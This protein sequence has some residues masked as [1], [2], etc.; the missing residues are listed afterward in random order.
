MTLEESGA[1]R[2]HIWLTAHVEPTLVCVRIF[3]YVSSLLY[4]H[5]LPTPPGPGDHSKDNLVFLFERAIL[6]IL[7]T[8]AELS[9]PGVKGSW[10]IDCVWEVWLWFK[11]G[12]FHS[13]RSF[14][15][16]PFFLPEDNTASP[17]SSHHDLG[18]LRMEER[19]AR[20]VCALDSLDDGWGTAYSFTPGTPWELI[21]F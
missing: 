4:S 1:E 16:F 10:L 19:G 11:N 5:S 18:K 9:L 21:R 8:H 6:F 20:K 13:D 12:R 7:C 2:L 17:G 3:L 15:F 14:L